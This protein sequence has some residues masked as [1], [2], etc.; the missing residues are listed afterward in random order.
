VIDAGID[1]GGLDDLL[2]MA[3]IGR[4]KTTRRWITW[5]RAWA[6]PSVLERRKE[7][8]ARLR[9]FAKAGDLVLVERIGDDVDEVAEICAQLEA[10]G[11]LDKIG[12]DPS[13]LGSILDGL[14]TAGIP[15][16]KIIGISQGWK[17]TGSIKTAERK[18]A[19]GVMVHGGQ[20]LMAWCVA[21]ARIEPR[22]NAVI[23]TKQASGS[24][25]IDPLIAVLNAVS[26]M[27]LN[28]A[29]ENSFWDN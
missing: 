24:A 26:L 15:E 6:H 29:P 18:L 2:G 25:K 27:S 9:D 12:V 22:G 10:S 16:D 19:E 3:A 4:C 13:G 8:A 17:M 23:I 21:N 14:Q 7:V 28:P 11:K 1:G 5:G 20:P